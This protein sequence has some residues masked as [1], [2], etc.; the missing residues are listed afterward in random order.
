MDDL[1]G[2]R[3]WGELFGPSQESESEIAAAKPR[4]TQ[5]PTGSESCFS[6]TSAELRDLGLLTQENRLL[7]VGPSSVRLPHSLICVP[8]PGSSESSEFSEE[9]SSGLE[10]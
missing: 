9:M 6:G 2:S 1:P 8:F 4:V 5:M 7:W 3:G 10:R